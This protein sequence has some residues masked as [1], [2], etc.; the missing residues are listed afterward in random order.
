[1][2]EVCRFCGGTEIVKIIP[3][4]GSANDAIEDECPLCLR[5][6]FEVHPKEVVEGPCINFVGG[7][8]GCANNPCG[9]NRYGECCKDYQIEGRG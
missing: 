4:G 2:N 5:R 8:T 3:C 7:R 1:M 9:S 6:M